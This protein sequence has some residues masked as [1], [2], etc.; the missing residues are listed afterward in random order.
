MY[1]TQASRK[2][3]R[4]LNSKRKKIK[5]INLIQNKIHFHNSQNPF[6]SPPLPI[7]TTTT[8]RLHRPTPHTQLNPPSRSLYTSKTPLRLPSTLKNRSKQTPS[9]PSRRFS[10]LST[11][12]AK[13]NNFLSNFTSFYL[14]SELVPPP[15]LKYQPQMIQVP[16]QFEIEE[17]LT[18]FNDF[19]SQTNEYY[20]DTALKCNKTRVFLPPS[21]ADYPFLPVTRAV[22][23][24]SIIHPGIHALDGIGQDE[25]DKL[26]QKKLRK[27]EKSIKKQLIDD[28][29]N[30][31]EDGAHDDDEDDGDEF[32]KNTNVKSNTQWSSTSSIVEQISEEKSGK[33]LWEEYMSTT[34]STKKAVLSSESSKSSKSS[35]SSELPQKIPKFKKPSKFHTKTQI[36]NAQNHF[37]NFSL[38]KPK[39]FGMSYTTRG[40]Y[41]LNSTMSGMLTTHII[42]PSLNRKAAYLIQDHP[43]YLNS[44]KL[45]YIIVPNHNYGEFSM[46]INQDVLGDEGLNEG[47]KWER[48]NE[49]EF[50][51]NVQN[52]QNDQNNNKRLKYFKNLLSQEDYDTYLGVYNS[53]KDEINNYNPLKQ[54]NVVSKLEHKKS[55]LK[56][57]TKIEKSFLSKQPAFEHRYDQVWFTNTMNEPS[58]GVLNAFQYPLE[59]DITPEDLP[60]F[61]FLPIDP[62]S[63][64][65]ITSQSSNNDVQTDNLISQMKSRKNKNQSEVGGKNNINNEQIELKNTQK[66]THK[67]FNDMSHYDTVRTSSLE[68]DGDDDADTWVNPFRHYSYDNYLSEI[69]PHQLKTQFYKPVLDPRDILKTIKNQISPTQINTFLPHYLTKSFYTSQFPLEYQLMNHPDSVLN[70]DIQ[71]GEFLG[72]QSVDKNDKNSTENIL[73]RLKNFKKLNPTPEPQTFLVPSD[74]IIRAIFSHL[75]SPSVQYQFM[76][77]HLLQMVGP[78]D[79][80]ASVDQNDDQSPHQKNQNN[81]KNIKTYFEQALAY[82]NDPKGDFLLKLAPLFYQKNPGDYDRLLSHPFLPSLFQ[83]LRHFVYQHYNPVIF[84]PTTT[85]NSKDTL[86]NGLNNLEIHLFSNC[87]VGADS[88]LTKGW[89]TN[90]GRKIQN[91]GRLIDIIDTPP[92]NQHNI[93]N[94]VKQNSNIRHNYGNNIVGSRPSTYNLVGNILTNSAHF[95]DILSP[96]EIVHISD[97]FRSKNNPAIIHGCVIHPETRKLITTFSATFGAPYD[98]SFYGYDGFASELKLYEILRGEHKAMGDFE[99][100][101]VGGNMKNF[102]NDREQNSI[103]QTLVVEQ[104]H[105]KT[106][107]KLFSQK[108]NMGPKHKVPWDID[109]WELPDSNVNV[110][111]V[112]GTKVTMKRN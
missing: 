76:P 65:I 73:S 85:I 42:P 54:G 74:S 97:F 107:T 71:S 83:N 28:N 86:N 96:D 95:Q 104:N 111:G 12:T 11:L 88:Y 105:F 66:D 80:D 30:N 112:F 78:P 67:S 43:N 61:P 1:K 103:E 63:M 35:Q 52:D 98:P 75:E 44:Y 8:T 21:R 68:D 92:E 106:P 27:I 10:K 39:E 33:T 19:S 101:N 6:P 29:D 72:E 81:Q 45:P 70:Q 62:S 93:S 60:G 3:Q 51:K 102:N 26:V 110:S 34:K 77:P 36:F 87:S 90:L 69:L 38:Q 59:R 48:K 22:D 64:N 41:V 24:S 31:D 91:T 82:N 2:P 37:W 5:N 9:H 58:S 23:T 47:L 56:Y 4:G 53:I 40:E 25:D 13:I 109:R 108:L 100:E 17:F 49:A 18:K 84:T 16:K 46:D 14:P 7:S 20:Q 99:R 57:L 50:E 15:Q 94:I 79:L 32:D 55:L 89:V